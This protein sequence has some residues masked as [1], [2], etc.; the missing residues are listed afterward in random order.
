MP[1][2]HLVRHGRAAAGWDDDPDPPLD[3]LGRDQAEAVAALLAPLGPLGLVSSPLQRT[4]QTAEPLA[5]RWGVEA[6]IEPTVREIPSPDG[7][8]MNRRTDWLREAL[9]G[10][11]ADLGPRYVEYRDTML[12]TLA[13]LE[14][15]T[16]VV[17]HFVAINAVVGACLGDD[18]VLLHSLDNCS[19]TVVEVGAGRFRLVKSGHEADTLIR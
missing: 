8:P 2:L 19:V 12:A 4:R 11:W 6:L 17:S 3:D 9:S 5:R 13:A 15:D 16:V 7:V 14:R 18:R 1:T 10:T